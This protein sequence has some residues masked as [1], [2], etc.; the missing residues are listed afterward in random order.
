MIEIEPNAELIVEPQATAERKLWH[1]PKFIMTTETRVS[2]GSPTSGDDTG[3][4]F[5]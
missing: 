2:N 3:A 1:A 4:G 5:S